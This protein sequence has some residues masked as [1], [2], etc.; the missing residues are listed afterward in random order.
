MKYLLTTL[1]L[2]PILFSI[3]GFVIL[4]LLLQPPEFTLLSIFSFVLESMVQLVI[5]YVICVPISIV[6][7][8]LLYKKIGNLWCG[9]TFAVIIALL[10]IISNDTIS[11]ILCVLLPLATIIHYHLFDIKESIRTWKEK[12]I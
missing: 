5:G 1:F 12:S 8:S 4:P 9:L 10:Y 3:Y 2:F 11:Q 6:I 7:S